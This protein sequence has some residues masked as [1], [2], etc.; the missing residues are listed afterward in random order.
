VWL[1]KTCCTFSDLDGEVIRTINGSIGKLHLQKPHFLTFES[2]FKLK[3]ADLKYKR[4]FV[5]H[6]LTRADH[7]E[8]KRLVAQAKAMAEQDV[9]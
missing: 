4:V 1:R 6:D 9:K 3:H 2:L 7:E 5:A 8:Y